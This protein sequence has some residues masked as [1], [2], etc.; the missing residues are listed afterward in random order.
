MSTTARDVNGKVIFTDELLREL[1]AYI[2]Q[3]DYTDDNITKTDIMSQ[4]EIFDWCVELMKRAKTQL[5]KISTPSRKFEV[6]TRSF[7]FH[8][9]LPHLL[10][11]L[12]AVV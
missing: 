6:T 12:R 4:D 2:K 3:A 9:N 1:S 5:S 8:S 11:N 10:R 7:I